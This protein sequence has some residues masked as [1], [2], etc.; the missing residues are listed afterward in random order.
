MWT[1]S[2][3]Q[4]LEDMCLSKSLLVQIEKEKNSRTPH[5][6]S[7]THAHSHTHA[8]YTGTHAMHTPMHSHTLHTCTHAMHMH[9]LDTRHA[10]TP[11]TGTH[12]T[13]AH[14]HAQHYTPCT[15]RTA[16]RK[17]FEGKRG[18]SNQTIIF[19]SWSCYLCQTHLFGSK[20]K[21][22]LHGGAAN[23]WSSSSRVGLVEPEP[24]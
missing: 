15:T 24:S 12:F 4:L 5:R 19:R 10:H 6:H 11:C 22:Q 23:L 9:T 13:H 2:S 18:Q 20:G 14:P 16:Q 3:S 8:P 1:I 21:V 17:K 7:S